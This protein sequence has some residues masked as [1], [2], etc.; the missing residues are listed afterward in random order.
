MNTRNA[1]LHQFAALPYAPL[2]PHQSHRR[3]VLATLNLGNKLRRKVHTES[4]RQH[5]QLRQA[6]YR[7]YSRDNGDCYSRCARTLH[8]REIFAVVEEHLCHRVCST[9]VCL[10][11]EHGKVTLHVRC[12]LMLLGVARYAERERHTLLFHYRAVGKETLVETVHLTHKVDGMHVAPLCRSS[13]R[14][15][16]T[17]VTAQHKDI[18]DTRKLKV[19]ERI[20]CIIE[21]VAVT[22]DMRHHRHI[23]A[24]MYCSSHSHSARTAAYAAQLE[25]SVAQILV[26]RLAVVG[27]YIYISGI[28][29][30]KT[31]DVTEQFSGTR[32]L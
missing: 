32:T 22:K 10:L 9:L 7:L 26:H 2:A 8:K 19:N 16:L 25:R 11:L 24:V 3:I 13:I 14:I 29:L 6:V 27:C 18:I 23:V 1:M 28:E 17:F 30:H 5:I 4:L 31:V 15:T 20:L 12:L 21:R